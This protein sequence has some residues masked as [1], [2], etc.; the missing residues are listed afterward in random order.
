MV[1]LVGGGSVIDGA[2]PLHVRLLVAYCADE[3]GQAERQKDRPNDRQTDRRT[4]R[5]TY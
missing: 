5:E 2:Y 4:G 1:E 3:R